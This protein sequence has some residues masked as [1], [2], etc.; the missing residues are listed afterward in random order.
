MNFKKIAITA[1]TG[2]LVLSMTM[3]AFAK[4]V[5]VN[6]DNKVKTDVVTSATTGD[7]KLKI[8][9]ADVDGNA[10]IRTGNAKAKSVIINKV[11]KTNLNCGC[12][13]EEDGKTIVVNKN[14]K[15]KT[16]VMT[17]ADTGSNALKIKKADVDGNASIRTGNAK[18][19]SVVINVVN[20]TTQGD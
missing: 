1:A 18:A 3:P 17:L 14:N 15:V 6:K 10:S 16:D 11:N 7:N 4:T 2:A 19:K 8:K 9:K 12:G 20:S 5:V 13:D